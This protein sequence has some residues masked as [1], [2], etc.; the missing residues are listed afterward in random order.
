MEKRA[1]Q[2]SGNFLLRWWWKRQSRIDAMRQE[3]A[4]TEGPYF[5]TALPFVLLLV[6]AIA[7]AFA[8]GFLSYRHVLLASTT[9]VV[10]QSSLCRADGSVNCDAILRT[11]Y[12][13][14][15]G[16]FPSAL[17]GLMGFVFVL[18]FALNG[19]FNQ[20]ARKVSWTLLVLYF[21][22]AIGFSWYYAY[23]MAFEVEFICT[24]C[25]VVHV[26]NLLSL[27]LV[28]V[29]A[30]RNRK[31][32]L[33]PEIST[34]AE[35]IY[36][37]VG[38]ILIS[39][40]VFTAAT[41]WESHLSFTDAKDQFEELANDPVVIRAVLE[42]SP[43]YQIPIQRGDPVYG[44]PDAPYP[45]ILFSDFKCPVCAKRD[46]FLKMLVDKNPKQLR[47]VFINY[48]LS[49]ECNEVVLHDLHPF[50]CTTAR[51]AYASFLLGGSKAFWAYGDKLFQNQKRLD[52]DMLLSIARELNL[53]LNKFNDL[54]KPDSI[55]AKKVEQDVR[56]GTELS[57]TS[58]P[59]IF[60]QGKRIPEMFQGEF[61]IEAMEG[62]IASKHPDKEPVDLK[63]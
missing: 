27:I 15:F 47:I 46:K 53:D 42:G 31:K 2:T 20:R 41:L 10:E 38:G 26:V 18:W 43:D 7:G 1:Q 16:Y 17:L 5:S 60:F 39:V 32:F 29:V 3:L 62:L 23:I 36:L 6:L 59:Q 9:G 25:I 37:V 19:L 22:A 50:A 61:L 45:I 40:L 30:I 35:R 4:V 28:L 8:T 34:L 11:E 49:M 63:F 21:F 54:M 12:S 56:L 24:W 55:A 33:Y 51:A 57:L 44:S 48:P 58:T 13:V 14:L 52:R